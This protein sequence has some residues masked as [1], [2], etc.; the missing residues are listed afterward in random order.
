MPSRTIIC[1]ASLGGQ[2][3]LQAM[4]KYPRLYDG[5]LPLCAAGADELLKQ[6]AWTAF[7][8]AYEVAFGWPDSWGL[9]ETSATTSISKPKRCRSCRRR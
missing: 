3:A 2:I 5:G 6:D 8:L 1:G 9:P 4:Q 7:A